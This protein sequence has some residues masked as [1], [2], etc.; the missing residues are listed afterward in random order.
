MAA[1]LVH[2]ATSKATSQFD[3][4]TI[5]D[6]I[7]HSLEKST[8]SA[9]K[10]ESELPEGARAALD[11]G[12]ET[13]VLTEM[14]EKYKPSVKDKAF[15]G[16]TS[17]QISLVNEQAG[18]EKIGKK[19]DIKNIEAI[20]QTEQT[21]PSGIVC[22]SFSFSLY[23]YWRSGSFYCIVRWLKTRILLCFGYLNRLTSST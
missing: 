2:R 23:S 9:K 4:A 10:V 1:S 17:L 16:F 14:P 19:L 15:S 22:S 18:I 21:I 3:A 12:I 7:P 20:V 5:N 6:S 8:P 11:L 13:K